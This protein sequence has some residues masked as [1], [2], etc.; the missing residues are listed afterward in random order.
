[1]I[2]KK[3]FEKIKGKRA[4]VGVEL[5]ILILASFA[6]AYIIHESDGVIEN[7]GK[8]SEDIEQYSE[9]IKNQ[10]EKPIFPV[11]SAAEL[12]CCSLA[13][14]GEECATS[15]QSECTG[16][17]SAN[18][19]C[20]QTSF[21][22]TGCCID[23]EVGTYDKNVLQSSCTLRGGRWEND[24][25]CNVAG[26]EFGCCILG[27]RT[28]FTTN[29][30]CIW[31]TERQGNGS[32][33]DWRNDL[34]EMQCVATSEIQEQGACIVSDNEFGRN[35]KFITEQECIGLTGSSSG[36]YKDFL[37]TSKELNT[38]CEKTEQTNCFEGKDGVYFVDSCGNM[39][40]IYDSNKTNDENYWEK[41]YSTDFSC[42]AFQGNA[43]SKDCGNC[44]RFLGGICSSALQDK[45][46][47]DKGNFYCK[48]TDCI[49][50]GD[51]YKNGESWCIYDG[52]IGD[53]DD[54]VGSRHWKY[55]CN[56]G[57]ISI[58]PC[59]D[60]RNQLCVQ[61]NENVGNGEIFKNAACR[62]NNWRECI[63]MNTKGGECSGVLDCET[64]QIN[65]GKGFNFKVCTPKNPG[66]FGFDERWQATAASVCGI[67]SRKCT[68]IYNKLCCTFVDV[69]IEVKL[70]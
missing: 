15:A 9:K 58:E 7:L 2:I 38:I 33:I 32:A 44:N 22:R 31:R 67:A 20:S 27:S 48:T 42:N 16:Q 39:A 62:P 60:Y 70:I 8:V 57:E 45:F 25:N 26:A 18:T 43:N 37:C 49:F 13:N 35:C 46:E 3:D 36:F 24:R 23:D 17:F 10:I 59:A 55:V 47:P 1:M 6:F 28:F 61:S 29:Q 66:G 50:K 68:V 56:L 12:G 4:I 34:N 65:F 51:T 14:S 52:K 54:V 41:I 5:V 69:T 30:N 53:G 19:L 63:E 11:V 40:N 21:C 64:K